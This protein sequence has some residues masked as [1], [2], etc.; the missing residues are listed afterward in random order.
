MYR[1]GRSPSRTAPFPT[2]PSRSPLSRAPCGSCGWTPSSRSPWRWAWRTFGTNG[3]QQRPPHSPRPSLLSYLSAP[4]VARVQ[5]RWENALSAV[6]SWNHS[7]FGGLAPSVSVAKKKK[8]LIALATVLGRSRPVRNGNSARILAP[9][10]HP[11][12]PLQPRPGRPPITRPHT[13]SVPRSDWPSV[14][15]GFG[16]FVRPSCAGEDLYSVERMGLCDKMDCPSGMLPTVNASPFPPHKSTAPH[17]SSRDPGQPPFP[18]WSRHR[19]CSSTPSWLHPPTSRPSVG[20][21]RQLARA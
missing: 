15:A 18:R 8:Y 4:T 21:S 10:A 12:T 6:A 17:S 19:A 5:D 13:P 11:G 3:G 20:F 7:L 9:P 14:S 16:W 2:C 1:G